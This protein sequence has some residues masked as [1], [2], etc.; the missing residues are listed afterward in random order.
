VFEHAVSGSLN[1]VSFLKIVSVSKNNIES[2]FIE[3]PLVPYA[4]PTA[5]TPAQP[6]LTVTSKQDQPGFDCEVCIAEGP[7]RASEYRIRR[8]RA[9]STPTDMPIAQT[10]SLNPPAS[11]KHV[12]RF[13]DAG[14]LENLGDFS[15]QPYTT[16]TWVAQV[17]AAAL[18]GSTKRPGWSVASPPVS[19]VYIPATQPVAVNNLVIQ[20]LSPTLILLRFEHPDELIGGAMGS[21]VIDVFGNKGVLATIS[22]EATATEGGRMLDRTGPFTLQIDDV[23]RGEQLRVVVVDPVGRSSPPVLLIAP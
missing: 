18:S 4:V 3:S 21:Y 6:L 11:G 1:V 10:G 7:V 19:S 22:A 9:S 5:D 14:L 13:E 8:S 12:E 2:G 16:Y 20:R 15:L 23:E 17:R